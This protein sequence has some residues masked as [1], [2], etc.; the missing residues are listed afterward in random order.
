MPE[1]DTM[2][3]YEE[4]SSNKLF[5]VIGENKDPSKIW[6]NGITP[7]QSREREG[8]VQDVVDESL[9]ILDKYQGMVKPPIE[10]SHGNT[11]FL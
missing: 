6:Y 9:D 8:Y 11:G 2:E 10:S 4:F 7:S 1:Y 5:H 3:K